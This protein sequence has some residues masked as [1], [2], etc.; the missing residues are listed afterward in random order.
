MRA[1][2]GLCTGLRIQPVLQAARARHADDPFADYALVQANLY[3]HGGVGLSPHADDE[4]FLTAG[5]PIYSFSLGATRPFS[6]YTTDDDKVLDVPLAHGD[7]L[8]M[9]GDMQTEFKHGIEKDRPAKYGPRINLT[10]RSV[11]ASTDGTA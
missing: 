8:M 5:A 1:C 7:L 2:P 10:V 9:T 6:I 3:A 4:P 11:R